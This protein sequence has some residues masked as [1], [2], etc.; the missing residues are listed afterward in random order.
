MKGGGGAMNSTWSARRT[1][2]TANRHGVRF[3]F[4]PSSFIRHPSS[5][6]FHLLSFILFLGVASAKGDSLMAVPVDGE[7]FA[8]QLA[9]VDYRW[10]ITFQAPEARRTISAASLVSWGRCVEA[11]R[12]PVVV[13]ADG[14]LMVA[15]VR[16]VDRE[17]L[18]AESRL[19][20]PVKLP[21]SGVAGVIFHLPADRDGRD[22]IVDR[23]LS[24]A[25]GATD[26]RGLMAGDA[27][28]L[29]LVNG[30]E[31][32]GTIERLADGKVRLQ[33]NV[34]PLELETSRATAVVFRASAALGEGPRGTEFLGA[35]IGF[36]DGTR[37]RVSSLVVG[38]NSLRATLPGGMALNAA[39]KELVFLQPFGGQVVYLSD[40]KPEGYR[41]VPF[42]SLAWPY[43]T[44]RNVAGGMLRGGGAVCLKGLGMHSASRLSYVL[45]GPF[46]RFQADLA[47]DDRTNGGGS[48]GFRVFVDGQVRYTSPIVRGGQAPVP[49]SVDL[50]G[51]KRIDLVVDYADRADEQDHANWLNARL[52]R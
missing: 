15:D 2:D 4:H 28:R 46:R 37:L 33:G 39:P 13:M 26:G 18:S 34:G 12:G 44:D 30:D 3:G 20:G 5:F 40:L 17:N 35:R 38:E 51:A 45:S 8:A 47:V 27:D 48:V 19:F 52:V 29:L 32:A 16:H 10:Q 24:A 36:R 50:V 1:S 25:T 31:V 23:I 9:A 42:L 6:I 43:R 49:V 7:P 41:H 21:R 22:R 14:G 11:D